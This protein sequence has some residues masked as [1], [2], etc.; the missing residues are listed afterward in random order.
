MIV[1]KDSIDIKFPKHSVIAYSLLYSSHQFIQEKHESHTIQI[2]PRND[3]KHVQD[4]STPSEHQL[5]AGYQTPF[6]NFGAIDPI[7]FRIVTFKLYI[8]SKE[9]FY[10]K[11]QFLHL[12]I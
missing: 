1:R 6:K 5:Q 4:L 10:D 11:L 2:H 12:K 8:D 3:D 9:F 7:N